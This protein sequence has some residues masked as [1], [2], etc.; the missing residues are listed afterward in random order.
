MTLRWML[1]A[2]FLAFGGAAFAQTAAPVQVQP[3]QPQLVAPSSPQPS[4]PAINLANMPIEDAVVLTFML[5]AQDARDDMRSMLAEMDTARRTRRALRQQNAQRQAR[6]AELRAGASV[7]S[8]PQTQ[9]PTV[10]A[11]QPN[12][13]ATQTLEAWRVCTGQI[14]ARLNSAQ[15]P[16]DDR[17]RLEPAL[18]SLRAELDAITGDDAASRQ[19]LDRSRQLV[20]SIANELDAMA[21]RQP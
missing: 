14:Q 2:T 10:A 21:A 9:T 8:A 7:T 12:P 15:L 5:A 17:R 20:A 4:A 18:A 3:R 6:A 13:C 16:A 1:A 11:A 19:H